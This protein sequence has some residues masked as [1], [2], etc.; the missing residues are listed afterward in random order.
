MEDQTGTEDQ[1][2]TNRNQLKIEIGKVDLE[3]L[4]MNSLTITAEKLQE[5]TD[6]Y[7]IDKPYISMFC[8]TEIKVDSI[9]F[10]PI[11]IKLYTKHRNKNEKEGVV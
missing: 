9:D 8:F 11:G 10:I 3:I 2:Q 1:T 4:L 5:V 6:K 7:L